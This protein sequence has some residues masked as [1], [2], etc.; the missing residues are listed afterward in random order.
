M[1]RF[2]RHVPNEEGTYETISLVRL[3]SDRSLAVQIETGTP[4]T[5]RKDPNDRTFVGLFDLD[6]DGIPLGN[7]SWEIAEET[8]YEGKDAAAL[9]VPGSVLSESAA[10]DLLL[11]SW[12]T[13]TTVCKDATGL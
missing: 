6:G 10:R 11:Q 13:G 1:I 8:A 9:G 5:W 4:E 12:E 2:T 3:K 7:E